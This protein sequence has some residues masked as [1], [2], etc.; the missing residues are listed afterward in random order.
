MIRIILVLVC[1]STYGFAADYKVDAPP[2]PLE[3][4]LTNVEWRLSQIENKLG[5]YPTTPHVAPAAATTVVPPGM[6]A[7]RTEDGR[8]IVHG[9]E[10]LGNAAAHQGIAHPWIRV[11]E[12]GQSVVTAQP[13]TT[14]TSSYSATYSSGCPNGVCP[15]SGTSSRQPWR[16][17]NGFFIRGN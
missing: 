5:M 4:R 16:P 7:H 6:H 17:F 8:I 15:T 13:I 12:A 9:N 14:A 2:S 3:R 1:A 10:N 11:A